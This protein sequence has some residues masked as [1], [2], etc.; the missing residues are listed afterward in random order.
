MAFILS[1]K[2][3]LMSIGLLFTALGLTATVPMMLEHVPVMWSFFL[4]C[5]KPPYLYV[6]VNAIIICIAASSRFHH[7]SA[8]AKSSEEETETDE[9][10]VKEVKAVVEEEEKGIIYDGKE[11]TWITRMDSTELDSLLLPEKPLVSA[12]FGHRKPP[13]SSPDGIIS[14]SSSSLLQSYQYAR[15]ANLIDRK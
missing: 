10:P 9:P 3:I 2:I 5:F 14:L 4:L 7:S 15:L 6:L 8:A 12:R 1:L 13:K 11:S